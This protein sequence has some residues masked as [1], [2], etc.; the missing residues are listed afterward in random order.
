MGQKKKRVEYD[1]KNNK[2]TLNFTEFENKMLVKI[3]YNRLLSVEE[4]LELPNLY[5]AF[6][7]IKGVSCTLC[8]KGDDSYTIE[9]FTEKLA[10]VHAI[11]HWNNKQ[12]FKLFKYCA[13]MCRYTAASYV[14]DIKQE[15][16]VFKSWRSMSSVGLK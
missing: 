6:K 14:W 16:K 3:L 5:K 1:I 2:F 4:Q 11:Y 8:G 10:I 7:K 15:S 12:R 9:E 13:I